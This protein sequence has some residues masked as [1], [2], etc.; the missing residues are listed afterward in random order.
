MDPYTPLSQ[1]H[2]Y[3]IIRLHQEM[4]Q[5]IKL[6]A[7]LRT[8][9]VVVAQWGENIHESK[10]AFEERRDKMQMEKKDRSGGNA[11]KKG[12]GAKSKRRAK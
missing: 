10:K 9:N 4:D 12:S 11:R 6:H 8:H 2:K 7:Q 3:Q 1:C 5:L